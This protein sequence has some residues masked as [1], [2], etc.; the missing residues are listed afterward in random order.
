[1]RDLLFERQQQLD[2]ADFPA[3]AAELG[4]DRAAF[5]DAFNAPAAAERIQQDIELAL[6]LDLKAM[7]VVYFDGRV[8]KEGLD[9]KLKLDEEL[10]SVLT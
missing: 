1:M 7:P 6:S 10:F 9:M 8:R 5:T 2:E 3:W 4:L